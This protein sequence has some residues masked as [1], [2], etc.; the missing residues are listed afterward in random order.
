MDSPSVK[1]PASPMMKR[2]GYGTG[3]NVYMLKRN[4]KNDVPRSPWAVKRLNQYGKK[5]KDRIMARMANEID[6]LKQF[7]HPNL[8]AFRTEYKAQD[9]FAMEMG[10][11]ALSD[12]IEQLSL[13]LEADGNE[14]IRFEPDYLIR[15]T[16][17]VASG[18]DY[19]HQTV[20]VLHGDLKPANILAKGNTFKICDFGTTLKL[21]ENKKCGF[22]DYC[23][24]KPFMPPEA[25]K[26]YYDSIEEAD[27]FLSPASDIWQLG[28][29]I[30]EALTLWPAHVLAVE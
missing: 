1:V 13:E 7:S 23:T 25:V 6:I 8:I 19:L 3:V 29:S 9:A 14:E 21:D 15:L 24:T 18:L 22:I 12:R 30:F 28:L 10:D 27:D 2:L 5:N 4:P 16:K 17:D 20:N 11:Y 26:E